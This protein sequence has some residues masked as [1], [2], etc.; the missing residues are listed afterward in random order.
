VNRPRFAQAVLDCPDPLSLAALYSALTGLEVEP[1]DDLAPEE[2][3]GIDL[4]N[5]GEPT[6]RF[7]IVEK[8]V[9]PPGRTAQYLNSSTSI[10]R[11]T[12]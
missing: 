3:T 10:L 2:I 5:D 1:L 8:Y 9:P 6:L 7:Q 4:L 11:W 12:I